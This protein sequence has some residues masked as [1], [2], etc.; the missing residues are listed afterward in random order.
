MSFF[1][2]RGSLMFA[3]L[4]SLGLLDRDLLLGLLSGVLE[5]FLG[6]LSGVLECLL[7]SLGERLLL[8]P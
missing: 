8:S 6:L 2:L 5:R 3:S 1:H 7:F 4:R